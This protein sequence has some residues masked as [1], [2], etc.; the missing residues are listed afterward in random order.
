MID[1]M[2]K[3]FPKKNRGF[4]VGLWATCNNFG[5]IAGIQLAAYLMDNVFNNKWQYLMV[6]ASAL[7]FIICIVTF[8]F[9]I[10]HP[11]Q[12]GISVEEMTEKEILIATAT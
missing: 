3:W 9:L 10:P 6:V 5:N 8:F 11:K 4:I 12:I 7:G 2:G 1:I